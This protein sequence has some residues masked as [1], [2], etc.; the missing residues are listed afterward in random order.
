MQ[1]EPTARSAATITHRLPGR[2]RL[3]IPA[4]RGDAAFFARVAEQAR[5]LP[6]V[7]AVRANPVTSGLLVEHEGEI[8]PIARDLGFDIVAP[9]PPVRHISRPVAR[10]SPFGLAAIGFG[11]ASV[12]QL[13]RGRVV[14]DSAVENLWNGF[15]AFRAL[16]RPGLATLLT[17]VGVA[18]LARG[19]LL[20]SA[21]SLAFYAA[22]ARALG[23]GQ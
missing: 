17:G 21:L 18:Q 6:T 7:R 20:N 13:A 8:E 2:T 22:S 5:G 1:D 9:K 19:R 3:R 4:R 16:R 23:R 11:A 10:P 14:G 15:T 12:V